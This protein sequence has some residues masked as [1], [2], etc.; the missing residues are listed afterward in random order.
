MGSIGPGPAY[1]LPSTIGYEK[2]DQR[3]V[4]SPQ[5]T[6][7]GR[8]KDRKA[9]ITPG[10]GINTQD[11]T[12]YGRATS[13]VYSMAPRTFVNDAKNIGPGPANYDLS[14]RAYVNFTAPPSY[15]LGRRNNINFKNQCPGPNAYGIKDGMVKTSA[16]A[17]SI[18]IKT[19]TKPKAGS[20]GPAN[21]P[22]GNLKTTMPKAPEYSMYARSNLN[23][24]SIV[25]G[26]NAYDRANYKPGKSSPAYSFGIRHSSKAPPM[27]VPCDKV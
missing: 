17:Y 15:S 27:I 18:G 12:R 3:K 10:P 19:D 25:P 26:A 8:L 16:P 23:N 4:R 14:K 20:P 24:K 9:S 1:T 7:G 22:A 21:Y 5:Y 2:H 6:M 11:L 13:K